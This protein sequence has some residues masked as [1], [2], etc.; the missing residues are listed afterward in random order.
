MWNKL[1]RTLTQLKLNK[2]N[3]ATGVTTKSI[4][5]FI[6]L[7]QCIALLKLNECSLITAAKTKEKIDQV[8]TISKG[9]K[10]KNEKP[11]LKDKAGLFIRADSQYY[12]KLYDNLPKKKKKRSFSNSS[13]S[14]L[15]SIKN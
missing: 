15:P 11:F 4:Y 13:H 8:K 3:I 2:P 9:E 12:L 14:S 10:C 1:E 5:L 6:S 7:A